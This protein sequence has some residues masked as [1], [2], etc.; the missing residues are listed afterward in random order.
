MIKLYNRTR[1]PDDAL[2]SL[3][4]EAARLAGA[5]GGIVVKVTATRR[6]RS[7]SGLAYRACSVSQQYLMG[8]GRRWIKTNDGY[9][10]LRVPI[11]AWDRE[12]SQSVARRV[13]QLAIHEFVHVR[14]YQ[15]GEDFSH[16][17]SL[18]R[19]PRW[20]DRIE[21]VRACEMTDEALSKLERMTERRAHIDA[22]IKAL[23][24]AME[25]T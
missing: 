22:L 1:L 21:E 13:F 4:V 10:V 19:R 9:I 17:T 20:E 7:A 24:Q 23:A 25:V 12:M 14:D 15:H 6:R 3:L 16:R 2:K 8:C 11:R 5:R 18:F